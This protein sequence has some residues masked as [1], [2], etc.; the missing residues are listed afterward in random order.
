MDFSLN[1]FRIYANIVAFISTMVDIQ[2]QK[3][4]KHYLLLLVWTSLG[5]YIT[6]K[7]KA[8][9]WATFFLGGLTMLAISVL[10]KL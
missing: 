9:A 7:T 6:F 5:A 2:I 8:L 10:T 1:R 3:M 4:K